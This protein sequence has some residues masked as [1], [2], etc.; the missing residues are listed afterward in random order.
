MTR[1]GP[2]HPPLDTPPP[3]PTQP[4][5]PPPSVYTPPLNPSP[6]TRP[7]PTPPNTLQGGGAPQTPKTK[8]LTQAQPNVVAGRSVLVDV[9]H[10]SSSAEYHRPRAGSAR[11]PGGTAGYGRHRPPDHRR[12]RP[13]NAIGWLLGLIGL[14][15]AVT[16][17]AEQYAL[18]GWPRPRGRCSRPGSPG[19]SPAPWPCSRWCSCSFSSC[20]SPDGRVPSRRWRP[21]R[22]ALYAVIAGTVAGQRRH[23][24]NRRF[25]ERA[26]RGGGQLP[27]PAGDL[28]AAQL[29]QQPDRSGLLP[30][31]ARRVLT[32]ASVFAR[33][34]GGPRTCVSSW[35]G[36]AMSAC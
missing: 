30:R 22:W 16:M 34:R 18:Y 33:R 15:L 32:A 9:P 29:V 2:E 5:T 14:S 28:P 7:N 20:C 27:Q 21:V 36:S 12:G 11:H 26:G 1:S 3:R 19:G 23:D 24:R 25:H 6:Q 31:G 4:P 8:N 13:G 35:P 10:S 17:L